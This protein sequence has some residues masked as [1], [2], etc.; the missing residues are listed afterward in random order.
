MSAHRMPLASRTF[1]PSTVTVPSSRAA[2]SVIDSTVACM[3]SNLAGAHRAVRGGLAHRQQ[4]GAQ[5][6]VGGEHDQPGGGLAQGLQGVEGQRGPV[7]GAPASRSPEAT[8]RAVMC[9]RGAQVSI[10]SIRWNRIVV[11]SPVPSRVRYGR[12]MPSWLQ[13]L[14]STQSSSPVV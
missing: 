8:L 7:A 13:N 6:V 4:R 9:S 5:P 11:S 12:P 10:R 14:L 3:R 1:S 2:S